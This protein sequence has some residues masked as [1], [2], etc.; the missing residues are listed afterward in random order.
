M[1]VI[2]LYKTVHVLRLLYILLQLVEVEAP[3]CGCEHS[4]DPIN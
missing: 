1:Q 4:S 2:N 3:C